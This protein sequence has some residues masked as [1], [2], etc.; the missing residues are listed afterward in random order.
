M[1][2]KSGIVE[3]ASDFSVKVLFVTS[4]DHHGTKDFTYSTWKYVDSRKKDSQDRAK[5]MLSLTKIL[6][7]I[8]GI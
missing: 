8:A 6:S 3:I 2:S 1:P 5:F 7:K 4:Y